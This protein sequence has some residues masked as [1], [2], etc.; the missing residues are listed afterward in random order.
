MKRPDLPSLALLVTLA[1]FGAAGL[2]PIESMWGFNHLAF[3]PIGW[4]YAYYV[5]CALVLF[6]TFYPRPMPILERSLDAVSVFLF[7]RGWWPKAVVALGFGALFWLFRAET[8]L[9][10]SLETHGDRHIVLKKRS[11]SA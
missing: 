6:L 8:H 11:K 9:L 5:V 1:L 4:T 7:G 3:L 10:G 2:W